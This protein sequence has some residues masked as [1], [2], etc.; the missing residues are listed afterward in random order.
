MVGHSKE[1]EIDLDVKCCPH[2]EGTICY[3]VHHLAGASA[4]DTPILFSLFLL[5]RTGVE[6]GCGDA[7]RSLTREEVEPPPSV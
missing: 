6:N 7:I 5:Y 3:R 1:F 4:T 2:N